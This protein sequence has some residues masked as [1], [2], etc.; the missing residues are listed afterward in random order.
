MLIE[1]FSV[2]DELELMGFDDN[3]L[4]GEAFFFVGNSVWD[5]SDNLGEMA[6]KMTVCLYRLSD[7]AQTDNVTNTLKTRRLCIMKIN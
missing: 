3:V 7:A 5:L 2:I 4:T 6:L 1:T